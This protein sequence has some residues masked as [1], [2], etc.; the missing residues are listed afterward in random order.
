MSLRRAPLPRRCPIPD[1]VSAKGYDRHIDVQWRAPAESAAEYY[2][3]SRSIDGQ[4]FVPVGIQR[5]GVNRFSDFIGRSGVTA[6]YNVA[7]ADWEGR[8]RDRRPPSRQR[9]AR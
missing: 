5:P 1:G 6:R 4:P 3:V 9:L 8:S 2:V 7:A